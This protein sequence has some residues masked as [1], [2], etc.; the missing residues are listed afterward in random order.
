MHL[1]DGLLWSPGVEKGIVLIIFIV[2]VVTG[3]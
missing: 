1:E 2:T 3:Q